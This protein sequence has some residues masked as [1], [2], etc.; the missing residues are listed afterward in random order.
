MDYYH[1]LVIDAKAD[2]EKARQKYGS[3]SDANYDVIWRALGASGMIWRMKC[4]L[5]IMYTLQ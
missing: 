5:N 1:K 2:Y 3:Y 4:N